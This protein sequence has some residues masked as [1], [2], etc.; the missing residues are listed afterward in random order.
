MKRLLV[1]TLLTVVLLIAA[2]TISLD[3]SGHVD[4]HISC[5]DFVRSRGGGCRT[6]WGQFLSLLWGLV[7][8]TIGSIWLRFQD[9]P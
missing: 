4:T 2:V 7:A 1:P 8:G 3:L 9:S 6:N 5:G